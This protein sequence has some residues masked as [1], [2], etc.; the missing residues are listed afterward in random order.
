MLPYMH[1]VMLPY[2]HYVMLPYMHYIMP[3]TCMDNIIQNK[4]TMSLSA[5]QCLTS[6]LFLSQAARVSY[7]CGRLKETGAFIYTNS[8]YD[9]QS[10][11]QDMDMYSNF[12]Q[13]LTLRVC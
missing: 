6:L 7:T 10:H 3:L 12:L 4:V 2:M 11:R 13:S 5:I 8:N 9:V 1:Y